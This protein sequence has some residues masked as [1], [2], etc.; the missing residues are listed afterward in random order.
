MSQAYGNRISHLGV[1][2]V[3]NEERNAVKNSQGMQ[4]KIERRI[5]A[6]PTTRQ[7]LA[8]KSEKHLEHLHIDILLFF[9]L[10]FTIES[11]RKDDSIFSYRTT[12]RKL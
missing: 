4:K 3:G 8:I 6:T 11:I 10:H 2:I 7:Q 5:F 1:E 9:L 12:T